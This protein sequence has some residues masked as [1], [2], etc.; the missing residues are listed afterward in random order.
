MASGINQDYEFL[1]KILIIGDTGCGKSC[2]LVRF[3]D[4]TFNENFISTIGVDFKIRTLKFDGKVVK[5]QI[6]DSAGQERFR[7]ITSSYYRGAHG[8]I[9]VYDITD[10]A[11][12][13]HVAMWL[14]EI[15]KFA[16]DNVSTIVVGNKSDLA[17]KRAVETERASDF[18]QRIGLPFLETSAKS[19]T[20]V[21]EAFLTMSRVIKDKVVSGALPLAQP[22]VKKPL[23]LNATPVTEKAGCCS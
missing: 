22:L 12:F 9:V 2:L 15:E 23:N 5:L 14:K 17:E 10:S 7:N 8:I 4:D 18:C 1:L 19:S 11:S 6:W 16:A 3:T 20:N 13:D 21:E